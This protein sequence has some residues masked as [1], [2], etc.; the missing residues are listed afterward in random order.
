MARMDSP[1]GRLSS[2]DAL[3]GLDMLCIAG[4][5]LLVLALA[6]AEPGSG[7]LQWLAEQFGHCRWEGLH[8]YDL[9]FPL[10]TFLA[11][12]SMSF[13][14]RKGGSK[15]RGLWRLARRALL[16]VLLGWAVNGTISFDAG[17]RYASVL[18]LIGISCLLGGGICLFTGWRGA[19]AAA[20]AILIGVGCWQLL[21]GSLTPTQCINAW[22]DQ[23]Y[24]PGRLHNG[25]YDPEGLLCIASATAMNLLGMLSGMWMFASGGLWRRCL[26][27][28][29]SGA[30]LWALGFLLLPVLGYPCIKNIWTSSFVLASAGIS[31]LLLAAFHLVVDVMPGG[32]ALA[33]PLRIIG[34]NALA[35]YLMTHVIDFGALVHRLF[36]GICSLFG[37]G[38]GI[39]F[40]LFYIASAWAV[41]ALL[42][43]RRVFFR[44]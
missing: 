5:E 28:A 25:S 41:L 14:L 37:E 33:L 31:M 38:S 30:A 22:L 26:G 29:G 44:I 1:Q 12:V 18:G 21:D 13:S 15:A 23:H 8:L 11:G 32:A 9:I 42:Y 24:L 16:L 6:Q 43:R 4:L 34:M 39:A 3:R 10:F 7:G 35:C 17:M 2:L 36:A 19:L 40:A 20:L 27:L